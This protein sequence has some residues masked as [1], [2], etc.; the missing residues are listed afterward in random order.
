MHSNTTVDPS[1]LYDPAVLPYRTTLL[2]KG[3][4][5][6]EIFECGD[7]WEGQPVKDTGS[8]PTKIVTMLHKNPVVPRDLGKLVEERI[9]V[10]PR[11]P[12]GA[13]LEVP[14]AEMVAPEAPPQGAPVGPEMQEVPLEG[15]VLK[16]GEKE[17]R[18]TSSL[19]P[20]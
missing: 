9:G 1:L 10:L 13:P 11:F 16:I 7:F 17:V 19:R 2:H 18:P 8:E 20:S 3:D 6:F 15:D 12:D 4:S 5:R 14:D